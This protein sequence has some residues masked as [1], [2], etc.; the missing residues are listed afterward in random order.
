MGKY[1]VKMIL[2]FAAVLTVDGASVGATSYD[3]YRNSESQAADSL[4]VVVQWNRVLLVIVRTPGAQS[5][6][7]HPTRSFAIMH[8]AIYDA[9]NAI[10]RSHKPYVVR[11]TDVSRF[12][13]RDAAAASAAHEVLAALYPK[14]QA[15]LDDL[16]QRSLASIPDGADSSEGVTLGKT[17]ILALRSNDRSGASPIPFAFTNP[18]A[19]GAYQSTPP[20]FPKQ[21]QFTHW[22][23]I[24]PF[25]LQRADQFRPGPP[26]G[27]TSDTYTDVF[28]EVKSLG[29]ANS[30]AATPDQA[31]TGRFWS[32]AIQNYWNEITQTAVLRHD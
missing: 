8:S 1:L 3:E 11:L 20:N 29:I 30:T 4:N 32:G 10:D 17:E 19:P 28:N 22:S 15:M 12:A 5:A 26:P 2:V 21:P 27:L 9:V 14:F 25:A 24:T 16:L 7:V 6:T 13:S 31:L 18:P 23:H